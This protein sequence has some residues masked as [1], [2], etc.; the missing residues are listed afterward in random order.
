MRANRLSELEAL[1]RLQEIKEQALKGGGDTV[2]EEL[3]GKRRNIGIYHLFQSEELLNGKEVD[4]ALMFDEI[5][6]SCEIVDWHKRI[7]IINKIELEFGDYLMDVMDLPMDKADE[8]TKKAIEI[9]I[10]S[11]K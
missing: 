2:P 8:L 10:A 6:S 7:D 1:K 5:L 4:A 11:S 3:Q 9:A